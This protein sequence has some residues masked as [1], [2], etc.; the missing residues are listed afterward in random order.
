MDIRLLKK[1]TAVM[2]TAAMLSLLVSCAARG[3]NANGSGIMPSGASN[4]DAPGNASK[5]D[6]ASSSIIIEYA[7]WSYDPP[8]TYEPSDVLCRGALVIENR[9]VG[10][11]KISGLKN[12]AVEDKINES[13]AAEY[14]RFSDPDFLPDVTGIQILKN[15]TKG[16]AYINTRVAGHIY[17][18]LSVECTYSRHYS[19]NYDSLGHVRYQFARENS[20]LNFDLRTGDLISLEDV[21]VD[22]TDP[23]KY[24]NSRL[25]DAVYEAAATD[26]GA[27]PYAVLISEFKGI[28]EDQPFYID[29]NG[30]LEICI[31]YKN[32]EFAPGN[33]LRL[34]CIDISS[35][36]ALKSRFGRIEGLYEGDSIEY[37]LRYHSAEG[38]YKKLETQIRPEILNEKKGGWL[39]SDVDIRTYEGC[40][41]SLNSFLSFADIGLD[42]L[43]SQVNS[44]YDRY[45]QEDPDCVFTVSAHSNAEFIGKY[46]QCSRGFFEHVNMPGQ[47]TSRSDIDIYEKR[48]YKQGEDE[49]LR[50][51]DLFTSGTDWKSVIKDA[52]LK[53]F[54][55]EHD[56]LMNNISDSDLLGFY[57]YLLDNTDDIGGFSLN[58]DKLFID[59]DMNEVQKKA[60]SYFDAPTL[61]NYAPDIAECFGIL[62]FSDLGYE[63]LAIFD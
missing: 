33:G 13:I 34:Y 15:W 61:A 5:P 38:G 39:Y 51:S 3:N 4:T 12:K 16:P 41:D 31:D 59:Y 23:V 9:V 19:Q 18:I 42:K 56:Y 24:V 28:R 45:M 22:G 25:I 60:D 6:N 20:Y 37:Y 14:A 62:Y 58:T 32:R 8:Q 49:P 53:R 47:S 44:D 2:L 26:I 7:D 1:L 36:S 43:A 52:A 10:P 57:D 50:I 21:F 30:D 46:M 40:G 63:N 54:H 11:V 17:N 55:R 35:V 29:D 48:L 27:D